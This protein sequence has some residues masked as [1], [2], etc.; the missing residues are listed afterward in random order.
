[1]EDREIRKIITT[2]N[3]WL[4]LELKVNNLKIELLSKHEQKMQF[5]VKDRSS[6]GPWL[7]AFRLKFVVFKFED[8]KFKSPPLAHKERELLSAHLVG[9]T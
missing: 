6:A 1:M 4:H 7:I 5:Y 8:G 9:V 3:E 2:S